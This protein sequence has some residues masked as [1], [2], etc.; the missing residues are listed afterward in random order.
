MWI[1]VLQYRSSSTATSITSVLSAKMKKRR[2]G[3]YKSQLTFSGTG[4]SAGGG[5]RCLFTISILLALCWWCFR[6]RIV[7]LLLLRRLLCPSMSFFPSFHDRQLILLLLFSIGDKLYTFFTSHTVN[8]VIIFHSSP[9]FFGCC[10][11]CYK[12]YSATCGFTWHDTIAFRSTALLPF[13]DLFIVTAATAAV[14]TVVVTVVMI[15]LGRA[16]F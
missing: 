12:N 8:L 13:L 9:F 11:C 4:I 16:L 15:K 2:N 1:N 3:K 6:K 14:W 7:L 5:D 10:C